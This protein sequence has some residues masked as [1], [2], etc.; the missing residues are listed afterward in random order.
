V[1]VLWR[2]GAGA[3]VVNVS[4]GQHVF[5]NLPGL[6]GTFFRKPEPIVN[7]KPAAIATPVGGS[8]PAGDLMAE[9]D[10]VNARLY[11]TIPGT[12]TV[13]WKP[14]E[15]AENAVEIRVSATLPFDPQRGISGHYPHIQGMPPVA[16]DPDPDDDF[17]FKSIKY[18]TS[19]AAADGDKLF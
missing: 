2:Y 19:E 8:S 5:E 14:G 18:S 10:P 6:A 1:K 9:W 7:A 15:D 12:F 3:V 11:P 4:I 17:K 13:P 16:L